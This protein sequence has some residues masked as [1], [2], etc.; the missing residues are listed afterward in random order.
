MHWTLSQVNSSALE[1]PQHPWQTNTHI[2]AGTRELIKHIRY[3]AKYL[4]EKPLPSRELNDLWT[5]SW[6]IISYKSY[7]SVRW[8]QNVTKCLALALALTQLANPTIMARLIQPSSGLWDGPVICTVPSHNRVHS[9]CPSNK[10]PSP[11]NKPPSPSTNLSPSS[12]LVLN[13]IIVTVMFC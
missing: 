6:S 9:P 11:S 13:S 8:K 3:S 12:A 1:H 5:S 2:V 10:P 7:R 4:C